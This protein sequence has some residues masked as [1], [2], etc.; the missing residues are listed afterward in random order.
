M[1]VSLPDRIDRI[2]ARPA[3]F[4]ISGFCDADLV[5]PKLADDLI[6]MSKEDRKELLHRGYG[7]SWFRPD[8]SDGIVYKAYK[9]GSIHG[10]LKLYY[11]PYYPT[12]MELITKGEKE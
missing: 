9:Q 1:G 5:T 12:E 3:N 7:F 8:A 6:H 11:N 4:D 2:F 10:T